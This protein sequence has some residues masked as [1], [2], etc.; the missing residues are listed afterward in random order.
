MWIGQLKFCNEKNARNVEI[1]TQKQERERER[2]RERREK[3]RALPLSRKQQ[4]ALG[5]VFTEKPEALYKLKIN[6]ESGKTAN[7]A[8]VRPLFL[9]FSF[10]FSHFLNGY[11]CCTFMDHLKKKV[12]MLYF[13]DK[14]VSSHPF[15]SGIRFVLCSVF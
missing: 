13:Y 14:L 1:E 2:E 4:K 5:C 6:T 9:F 7:S 12:L 3:L 8:K 10:L 15:W 11:P